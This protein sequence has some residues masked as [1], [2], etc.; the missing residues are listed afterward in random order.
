MLYEPMNR[1]QQYLLLGELEIKTRCH[2]NEIQ[3]YTS[4]SA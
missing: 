2:C 1:P 4:E 3:G